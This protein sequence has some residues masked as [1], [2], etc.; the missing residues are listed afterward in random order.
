MPSANASARPWNAVCRGLF[1]LLVGMLAS[2]PSAEIFTNVLDPRAPSFAS[3]TELADTIVVSINAVR[4]TS[5][6]H[7]RK[8]RKVGKAAIPCGAK[9][10]RKTKTSTRL[11]QDRSSSVCVEYSNGMLGL[12]SK[13]AGSD[14]LVEWIPVRLS[15]AARS[16]IERARLL[17]LEGSTLLELELLERSGENEGRL[18]DRSLI[19]IDP[20]RERYLLNVMRSHEA[21][22]SGGEGNFTE[23]CEGVAQIRGNLVVL[24]GYACQE[25]SESESPSGEL[26]TYTRSTGPDP[27]FS[28]RYRNGFLYQDR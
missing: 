17:V 8:A 5:S 9:A 6:D 10:G 3:K 7:R 18:E 12:R 2:A 28:Y 15:D 1:A 11:L 14:S 13:R 22:G 24:G 25:E 19:L 16:S 27:E 23:S 4:G 26:S 20:V 21:E